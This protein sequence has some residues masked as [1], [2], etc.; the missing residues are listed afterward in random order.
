[1]ILTY[2]LAVIIILI[3]VVYFYMKKT[4]KQ[5]EEFY[6]LNGRLNERDFNLDTEGKHFSWEEV[7]PYL[8]NVLVRENYKQHKSCP[9]CNLPSG[10]L[11]WVNYSSPKEDWDH[12]AGRCGPLS[13][14]PNC[15]IQVEFVCEIIS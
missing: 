7:K 5:K 9:K 8:D 14:C 15:K 3:A 4:S 12:L 2:I 13:I 6:R 10:Q 1:M 11:V